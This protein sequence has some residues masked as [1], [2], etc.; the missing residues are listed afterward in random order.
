MRRRS[1]ECEVV[2]TALLLNCRIVRCPSETIRKRVA[3][4]DSGHLLRGI[5]GLR[6]EIDLPRPHAASAL[7]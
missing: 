3:L 5:K 1:F 6:G 4:V 7:R 2:V